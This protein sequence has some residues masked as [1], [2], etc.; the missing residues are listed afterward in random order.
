MGSAVSVG[1][2]V[3]GVGV[4]VGVMVEVIVGV[5]VGSTT[6]PVSW[7]AKKTR[8][9]PI[10][11]KRANKIKAI[12]K[13][14]VIWGMRLPW[15]FLDLPVACSV[16]DKSVPHTRQREASSLTRVPQV[17]QSLVG[18]EGDSEVISNIKTR[19]NLAAGIIPA[20]YP[21]CAKILIW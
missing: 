9:A 10:P 15:I 2:G 20:F 5:M 6:R 19:R 17:G 14:N 1:T 21:L 13:L 3:S 16:P 7:R 18:F 12:G 8:T 11:R 4:I